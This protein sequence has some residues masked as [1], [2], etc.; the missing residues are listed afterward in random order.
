MTGVALDGN[1]MPLCPSWF[2]EDSVLLTT[3]IL[4]HSCQ[5]ARGSDRRSPFSISEKSTQ[6]LESD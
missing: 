2:R 3:E 5:M 4:G 1:F 6:T